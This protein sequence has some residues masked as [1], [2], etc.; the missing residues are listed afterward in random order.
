M[1]KHRPGEDIVRYMDSR[2][3]YAQ[4]SLADSWEDIVR[5]LLS[6]PAVLLVFFRN[7]Q[8]ETIPYVRETGAE[9]VSQK[10][11]STVLST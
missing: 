9:P 11:E 7:R 10:E 4:A 1:A 2:I 5:S 6:G 8:K 3:G